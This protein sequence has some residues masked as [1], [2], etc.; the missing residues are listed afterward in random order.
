MNVTLRIVYF[1]IIVLTS[2]GCIPLRNIVYFQRDKTNNTPDSLPE[3]KN[4]DYEFTIAPYDIL[5]LAIDG[6]DPQSFAAFK[7]SGQTGGSGRPYDQGTF[8]NKYGLI[9]LPYVG[10]IKVSGLTLIQ[11]ADTIRSRLLLYVVDSS[12]IYI[13]VKTLSFPVTVLGEVSSPG[14]Y[15]ADNE[16][17]TFT[18]LLAKAGGL[19][20]YSNRKNIRLIRSDRETKETTTYRLDITKDEMI[21]PIISRLQPN[22][23]IYV[24]PLRRKQLDTIRPITAIVST[25][26]SV[27]V[28]IITLINRI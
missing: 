22:D 18:E 12:L 10:K 28:L 24:E 9:E 1:F 6:I 3:F 7:P 17:I 25:V 2:Y 23:V 26:L 11:A 15:Q 20:G 16:Y 19:T 4:Q 14:T 8:V 5:S 13:Q 27:S 21:E